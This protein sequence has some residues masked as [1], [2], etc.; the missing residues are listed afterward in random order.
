MQLVGMHPA[1]VLPA[2]SSIITQNTAACLVQLWY[3]LVSMAT[4]DHLAMLPGLL[5]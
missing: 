1:K 4:M 3:V 5:H 2:Y